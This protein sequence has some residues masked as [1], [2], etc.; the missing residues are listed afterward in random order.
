[1]TKLLLT[2]Q[3]LGTLGTSLNSK[4]TFWNCLQ[5]VIEGTGVGCQRIEVGGQRTGGQKT[6]NRKG[7]REEIT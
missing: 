3:R 1:M 7:E 5:I 6:G 2:F 4:I